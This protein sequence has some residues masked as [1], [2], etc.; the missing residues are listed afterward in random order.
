MFNTLTFNSKGVVVN[1]HQ[2]PKSV[3][4]IKSGTALLLGLVILATASFG[5]NLA[6]NKP[7]TASSVETSL[8][9]ANLA[10]DGNTTTRW[11]SAF[12]D[13][14][15]IRIDLGTSTV[16][17]RVVLRWEAASAKNYTVDVSADGNS[18]T[19]I[20]T[21]TNMAAGARTDDFSGLAGT[22]RYIRMNGTA[23]TTAYGYSLYEF[24]VYGSTP[25][26]Y[27]LTASAVPAAGGSITLN[28]AGGSYASG[29]SVTVTATPN[30]GYT[31]AN[32][33]GDLT[34]TTNP[35][36]VTMN[37]N[38]AITANFSVGTFSITAT[39]GANGSISPSG[40][41]S[42]AYGANQTFIVSPNTGYVVD[43]VTVDGTG[44]GSI[45]S[46]TFNSVTANHTISATFKTGPTP[47]SSNSNKLSFNGQLYSSSGV[48]IGS[49]TPVN[50]AMIVDLYNDATAGSLLYS[51]SFSAIT[52]NNGNFTVRLGEG[53]TTGKLVDVVNANANLW[54]Q[55]T[56]NDGSF[57][58][59][60][61]RTPL[62]ASAYGLSASRVLTGTVDPT[63]TSPT[64]AIG[65]YY[66]N[67]TASPN[68]T[69]VKTQTGWTK[70][71]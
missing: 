56:V 38:K 50:V 5:Q 69:W 34:G 46:Y 28:P 67:T 52:V 10:V 37:S 14:Q 32:F 59:L 65:T 48:A 53:T 27:T 47:T 45:G 11:S 30:T 42:V 44:Q 55:L 57:D 35:A 16:V 1:Y 4:F 61:P 9:T 3:S 29:T 49:P 7:A 70:L 6:L 12:S 36:T 62:T 33:S 54:A 21:K 23:R 66:V 43:V 31:F 68:T 15:W 58:V 64:A 51:E 19:T 17:N 25:A 26:N 13:P 22:G 24:E 71:N 20:L 18:W 39:A 8:L 63:A 40:S 60:Q 2:C 41:V